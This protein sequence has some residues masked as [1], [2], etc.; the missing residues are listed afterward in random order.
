M[1][2]KITDEF[3]NRANP[4]SDAYPNGSLKDETNPGVSNDGSPLSSRVGND[5]QG[6]M[7]SALSEA[8]IDANGNPDS[9][10]NPQILNSIKSITD[11]RFNYDGLVYQGAGNISDHAGQQLQEAN[12]TNAYQ[13]PDNSRKFYAADKSQAFPVAIPSDPSVDNNWYLVNAVTT[14]SL[15][16]LTNYQ[17]DSVADMINGNAL[18]GSVTQKVGQVWDTSAY[19][20]PVSSRWIIVSSGAGD[21]T[22]GTLL[23]NSG[24]YASLT[25][26]FYGNAL[27]FGA[28]GNKLV[29]DLPYFELAVQAS[30]NAVIL[31]GKIYAP[32]TVAGYRVS[33][34]LDLTLAD[35]NGDGIERT[36]IFFDDIAAN[37]I[38]S[39][40]NTS[41]SDVNIDGGWDGTTPGL[42]GD[43]LSAFGAGGFT[44][45]FNLTNV[46]LKNARRDSVAL[47]RIG[48]SQ[49]YNVRSNASGRHG[50]HLDGQAFGNVTSLSTYGCVFSDC[51]YGYGVRQ[52]DGHNITHIGLI[53][54][55]TLGYEL[56]GSQMRATSLQGYY[57]EFGAGTDY[58]TLSGSGIGLEITGGFGGGKQLT[59]SS[60]YLS[61]DVKANSNVSHGILAGNDY[62][63]TT[64]SEVAVVS[65]GVTESTLAQVT[66]QPGVYLLSFRVQSKSQAPG[67]MLNSLWAQVTSNVADSGKNI[68]TGV[69]YNDLA[70]GRL[71]PNELEVSLS[72]GN[73]KVDVTVATTYYLRCQVDVAAVGILLR[74][75]I[76]MEPLQ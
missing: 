5:F 56:A 62:I 73:M 48:Y 30:K 14:E 59:S 6:F 20:Y 40:G 34:G 49:F 42:A 66:L 52:Y 71:C 46:R 21:M 7:Q 47:S 26:K 8:G 65:T 58:V 10:D 50:L 45:R 23:L 54:E 9:V 67:S 13:Y 33:P 51:P 72:S 32:A 38:I 27:E 12:K 19:N 4:P 3:G 75:T 11:D 31:T 22:D 1:A 68:A 24:L 17:A 53:S 74:G 63:K 64:G 55:F 60:N 43:I 16:C 29:D 44:G 69:T 39:N 37:C 36:K 41:I 61:P 2:I 70:D 76:Q 28:F 15:G 25:T 57:N 35:F 18:G